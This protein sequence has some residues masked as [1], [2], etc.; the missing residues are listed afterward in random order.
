MTNEVNN[1]VIET[2]VEEVAVEA[3]SIGTVELRTYVVDSLA[4]EHAVLMQDIGEYIQSDNAAI[5]F[6]LIVSGAPHGVGLVKDNEGAKATFNELVPQHL[7]MA[8]ATY[9]ITAVRKITNKQHVI[10]LI[11]ATKNGE[12]DDYCVPAEELENINTKYPV[13]VA[14]VGM[15]GQSLS[16]LEGV[17]G[18]LFAE[19][20]GEAGYT[21]PLL[22][23]IKD[24]KFTVVFKH[25]PDTDAVIRLLALEEKSFLDTPEGMALWIQAHDFVFSALHQVFGADEDLRNLYIMA[26]AV[27][28]E[29]TEGEFTEEVKE[30]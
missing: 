20:K 10:E 8:L 26:E 6:V 29:I 4:E 24:E 15:I 2:A 1:E 14:V 25:S 23:D 27:E 11:E 30:D 16:M 5:D 7:H 19:L 17:V 9:L 22:L 21:Q 12:T 3:E 13:N 28:E 18:A